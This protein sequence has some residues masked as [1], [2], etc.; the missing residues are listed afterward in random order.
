MSD[1][2]SCIFCNIV[3]GKTPASFVFE[4]ERVVAFA[5]LH[6]Q[7]PTHVLFVPRE[8]IATVND[9]SDAQASLFT[10]L[11]LAARAFA[12]ERGFADDGYRLVM[13]CN[14]QGGQTVFHLHLHLLAGQPLAGGF[15]A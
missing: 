7:A 12:R 3:A 8:H 1:T 14:R 11:V 10:D 15:G 2:Q 9:V 5:D 6:P 4:T 13:N